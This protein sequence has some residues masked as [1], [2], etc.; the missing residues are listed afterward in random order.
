ML[1]KPCAP[2]LGLRI[3]GCLG[4]GA[5]AQ[6]FRIFGGYE[7]LMQSLLPL[8]TPPIWVWEGGF[9]LLRSS[10]PGPT[11]CVTCPQRRRALWPGEKR[12]ERLQI[13]QGEE[14][15]EPKRPCEACAHQPPYSKSGAPRAA[16]ALGRRPLVAEREHYERFSDRIDTLLRSKQE[17]LAWSTEKRERRGQ[18]QAKKGGKG[19]PEGIKSGQEGANTPPATIELLLL[20]SRV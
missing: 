20:Q 1:L 17:W 19:Q 6:G 15:K 9:Q 16:W 14:G 18:G 5:G 10:S 12:G 8:P 2:D 11:S 4:L 7:T 3:Q 13:S